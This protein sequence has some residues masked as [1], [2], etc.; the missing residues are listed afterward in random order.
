[1]AGTCNIKKEIRKK[2]NKEIYEIYKNYEVL[3]SFS[4]ATELNNKINNLYNYNISKIIPIDDKFKVAIKENNLEKVIE[5]KTI[6]QISLQE[7][8]EK[9][10]SF[11]K[12]DL[13]VSNK[14]SKKNNIKEEVK[15]DKYS[16]KL[17]LESIKKHYGD[18]AYEV[19][20]NLIED[21]GNI[22]K[23]NANSIV[24]NEEFPSLI[25]VNYNKRFRPK[26][27]KQAKAMLISNIE[28]VRKRISE[29]LGDKVKADQWIKFG[30]NGN[31]HYVSINIPNNFLVFIN[32]E[33]EKYY[34][35]EEHKIN[36]TKTF[37]GRNLDYFNNDEALYEQEELNLNNLTKLEVLNNFTKSEWSKL[38]YKEK[39]KINKEGTKDEM[40]D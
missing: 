40:C 14:T 15:N 1:M 22:F 7:K 30:F 32:E 3:N 34:I 39:N 37:T 12:D 33:F 17:L 23:G 28:R 6:K 25:T 38:T 16:S 29:K 10:H 20:R 24:I 4:K 27:D 36:N 9:T 2:V 5:E 8:L 26:T 19:R 13:F 31:N 35:E 18:D 21:I 11:L